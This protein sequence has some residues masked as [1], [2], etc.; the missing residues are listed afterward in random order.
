MGIFNF[1]KNHF[2]SKPF[3][4]IKLNIREFY[5]DSVPCPNCRVK[6]VPDMEPQLRIASDVVCDRCPDCDTFITLYLIPKSEPL[7]GVIEGFKS[8][9]KMQKRVDTILEN[10]KG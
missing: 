2:G 9:G 3:C 5:N 10:A 6:F 4:S 8:I 1:L 7:A